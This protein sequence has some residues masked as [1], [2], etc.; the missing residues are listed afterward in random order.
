MIPGKLDR[1]ECAGRPT[2]S[3]PLACGTPG[4]ACYF[5]MPADAQTQDCAR[6]SGYLRRADESTN[7]SS[8]GLWPRPSDQTGRFERPVHEQTSVRAT[9]PERGSHR[10]GS[11]FALC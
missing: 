6:V 10:S 1:V 4:T 3:G 8:A 2:I 7:P 11:R 9:K 5:R